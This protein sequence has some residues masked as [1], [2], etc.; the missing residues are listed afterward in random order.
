MFRRIA[1]LVAASALALSISLAFAVPAAAQE[2]PADLETLPPVPTDFT[3]EKLP[4]GDYDFTGTWPIEPINNGRILFQRP[5]QYGNRYWVTD[6]EFARRVEAARDP[7]DGGDPVRTGL[8]QQTDR[9]HAGI[10]GA[11][12]GQAVAG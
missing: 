2:R 11:G 3:P 6:E 8:G 9:G 5:E 4:W 12:A 1:P 10:V 7:S